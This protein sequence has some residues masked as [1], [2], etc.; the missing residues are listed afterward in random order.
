MTPQGDYQ[1][2]LLALIGE[3]PA[4][5]PTADEIEAAGPPELEEI[6]EENY[7]VSACGLCLYD[8]KCSP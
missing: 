7:P 6:E 2:V 3:R 8:Q 1:A 4:P 5:E